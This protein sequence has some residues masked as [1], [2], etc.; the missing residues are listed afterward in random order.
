MRKALRVSSDALVD[1][2]NNRRAQDV[3]TSAFSL[4]VSLYPTVSDTSVSNFNRTLVCGVALPVVLV[5]LFMIAA[6][7]C[8]R[9]HDESK[10]G[11]S[12]K[13]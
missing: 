1:T 11:D 3:N 10:T 6:I 12:L 2:D 13:D 4:D 8:R 7:C 9:F 5:L